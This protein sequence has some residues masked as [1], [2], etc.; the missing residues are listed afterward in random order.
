MYVIRLHCVCNSNSNVMQ[1][2]KRGVY[3]PVCIKIKIK[4]YKKGLVHRY[5]R[6]HS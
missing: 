4:I 3:E 2:R 1:V 6:A 5:E